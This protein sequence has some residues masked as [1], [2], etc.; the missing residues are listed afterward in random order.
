MPRG[1]LLPFA[2][3]P[4]SWNFSDLLIAGR[5]TPS[6]SAVFL[7]RIAYRW[8]QI[9]ARAFGEFKHSDHDRWFTISK[10]LVSARP[11]S[12]KSFPVPQPPRKDWPKSKLKPSRRRKADWVRS[13]RNWQ[14]FASSKR[15]RRGIDLVLYRCRACDDYTS[16]SN[17]RRVS[18]SPM[19][20][21]I[22]A[23]ALAA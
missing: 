21:R 3:F 22:S 15:I 12:K 17:Y 9:I 16:W 23:L 18:R 6:Y 7:A 8:R 13:S 2:T 4:N 14:L 5:S 1:R 11:S 10:R 20:W 19:R